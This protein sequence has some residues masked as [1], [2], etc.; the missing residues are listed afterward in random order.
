[1]AAA[2]GE[3]E[4]VATLDASDL[5]G[6]VEV[7]VDGRMSNAVP[8]TA[9]RG[10]FHLQTR[11][12]SN[13]PPGMS[14]DVDCTLHLRAD[15]H[16]Y[17]EEPGTPPS[18]AWV[19]FDS[20]E[21]SSCSAA[22]SGSHTESGTTWTASGTPALTWFPSPE[23]YPPGAVNAFVFSGYFDVDL[24]QAGLVFSGAAEGT[25]TATS[26]DGSETQPYWDTFLPP[27]P[28]DL[29]S[30]YRFTPASVVY[31][32]GTGDTVS[33][34]QQLGPEHAPGADTES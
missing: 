13:F 29:G 10:S 24:A 25:L 30:D 2:W 17:R 1:M 6:A 8:L 23:Q 22:M 12:V 26:A 14:T 9:W 21:G 20:V 33:V 18:K 7:E 16:D 3:S 5:D 15:V 31:D 27:P 32:K 4:I 28:F 11:N 19:R 34:E